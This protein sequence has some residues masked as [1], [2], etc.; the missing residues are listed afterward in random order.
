[1]QVEKSKIEIMKKNN[2]KLNNSN[3]IDKITYNHNR[4]MLNGIGNGTKIEI[5]GGLKMESYDIIES[6][7]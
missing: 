5:I 3:M 4:M 7:H 6:T 2:E 1:M